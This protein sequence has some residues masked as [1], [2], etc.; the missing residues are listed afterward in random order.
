MKHMKVIACGVIA[1]FAFA[2]SNTN[3]QVFELRTYVTNEGK[4]DELHK[5]FADHT[6]KFFEKHG[7]KNL[8]Y[9]TPTDEAASKNTL[10]YVIEHKSRDAAAASWKSFIADPEWK[11]VAKAS[12][13]DGKILAQ[14][15]GSI[16]MTAAEY[17]MA[18]DM[19]PKG[20]DTL[21]EMRTYKTNEGKLPNLN[22]RFKDHTIAIFKKHGM[23]SVAYW[24]PMDDPDKKDT[25]IYIIRHKSADAA[26]ASW[27]AFK[28]DPDWKKVAKESQVDGRILAKRPDAVYMKAT[29]WSPHITK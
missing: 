14:R 26:K 10:I 7:M 25:L 18:F 4:L 9:F 5:R 16:Y 11:K 22:T 12:Q 28:A 1:A 23:E 27:D 2:A 6:L 15:P 21:Y 3:A 19:G 8:G 24:H 13:V 29:S 20:A 17:S